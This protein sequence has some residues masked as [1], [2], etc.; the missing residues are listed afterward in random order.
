[1]GDDKTTVIEYELEEDFIS[2]IY[3]DIEESNVYFIVLQ[4][5]IEN[6]YDMCNVVGHN[7][8]PGYNKAC[9]LRYE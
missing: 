6:F 4:H 8:D 3:S 1:M 5:N 9:K 2:F 7:H